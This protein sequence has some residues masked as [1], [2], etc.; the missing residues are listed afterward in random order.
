M[1]NEEKVVDDGAAHVLDL[2][3]KFLVITMMVLG[4]MIW[5]SPKKIKK[6]QQFVRL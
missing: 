6:A 4:T 3:H 2:W 1:Y 5:Q